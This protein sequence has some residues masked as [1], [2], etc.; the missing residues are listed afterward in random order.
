MQLA[1]RPIFPMPAR[2]TSAGAIMAIVSFAA[3]AVSPAVGA[4]VQAVCP[5]SSAVAVVRAFHLSRWVV[6]A[7]LTGADDHW[8]GAGE[9]WTMLHAEILEAYKGHPPPRLDVLTHGDDAGVWLDRGS[10]RDVG[11]EYLLFLRPAP[12]APIHGA[13]QV[14]DPC[15]KSEPW[16]RVSHEEARSLKSPFGPRLPP[17]HS[18]SRS[19]AGAH[20]GRGEVVHASTQRSSHRWR[21]PAPLRALFSHHSD[22][23]V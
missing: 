12:D 14:S 15:G 11:Q 1:P 8:G 4:P 5:R 21:W 17:A 13:A 23:D 16:I 2:A 20:H 9:S 19:R 10:L 3:A 7:R 18:F 6:R 22:S